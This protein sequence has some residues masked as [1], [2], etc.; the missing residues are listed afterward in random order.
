MNVKIY[1][2]LKHLDNIT[3]QVGQGIVLFNLLLV[4]L[5]GLLLSLQL[6]LDPAQLQD[7]ELFS[8]PNHHILVEAKTLWE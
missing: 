4:L 3:D 7:I 1:I 2:N 6:V 8:R 5:D